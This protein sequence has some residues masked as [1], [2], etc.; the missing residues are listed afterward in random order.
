MKSEDQTKKELE[1]KTLTEHQT[2]DPSKTQAINVI[3]NGTSVAVKAP[4]EVEVE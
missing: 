3:A 4:T 1:V 2:S